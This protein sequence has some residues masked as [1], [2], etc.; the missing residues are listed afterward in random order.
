MHR[1]SDSYHKIS[2]YWG[3]LTY[4]YPFCI[5]MLSLLYP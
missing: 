5:I 3:E 1:A 4:S 2:L